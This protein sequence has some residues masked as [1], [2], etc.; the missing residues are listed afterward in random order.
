VEM[1]PLSSSSN[2]LK[3]SFNSIKKCMIKY[4]YYYQRD[5]KI[6]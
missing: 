1:L 4:W 2:R 3:A 6:G 5:S